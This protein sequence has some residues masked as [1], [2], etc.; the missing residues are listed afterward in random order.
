MNVLQERISGI[1]ISPNEKS[2]R[3]INIKIKEE[4]LDKLIF[5]F[6]KFTIQALEYKPFTRFTI[7]KSLDELFL[8][9]LSKLIYS[10][11]TDRNTGCFIVV[12][13]IINKKFDDTF[14]VKLSTALAY[15]IGVANFDD[16]TSKYYARFFIK[17][18][19]NSDSYLRKAYTNMDLHT[20]GTYVKEK[21]DWL[22]MTKLE[23]KN[24]EGGE[25]VMLHL[26]DWEHC[27]E[28][29]N[30]PV[31]KQNFVW[32]SPKSKN[33]DYKIE[34]SV[35]SKDSRG[36]SQISYIDQFPEPQ[37]MEQ[38]NFL[39]KL[40]DALEE[41]KNK[42]VLPLPAGSVIVANNFFWLHGRKSFK[43]NKNLSREL[44]RIRGHFNN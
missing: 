40:S 6:H 25:S 34:H 17:H 36:R 10:V 44:L 18:E 41:S 2:K 39:Q 42:I 37:N 22:L 5:P 14:L 9:K 31:G 30:D 11:L 20:D 13:E 32:G 1:E 16:M 4:I 43:E 33:V 7:A 35:F 12:P 8:N 26:D 29:S 3:I 21:T 27:K 19:D 38:G 23:E 28:F 24:V 15:L